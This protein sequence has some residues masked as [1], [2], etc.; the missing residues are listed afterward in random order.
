MKRKRPRIL[1]FGPPG[2]GKSSQAALLAKRFG[3]PLICS[4]ELFRKEVKEGEALGTMAEPYVEAG[5]LVPDEVTY[6]I[7][8]KQLKE[9]A[10][11]GGF[12]LDGYPRNVEQAEALDKILKINLAV[13]LRIKDDPAVKRQ[14]KR[15]E[16][17][18]RRELAVYHFMTEPL[19]SYYRQRGVLLA[20]NAEQPSAS[21]F[22][23]LVR[24]MAKLGFVA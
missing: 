7:M 24:K 10:L 18:V 14:P 8:K 19:A 6:A 20:V 17:S 3:V 22:E 4:G 2:A 23:E 5:V 12:V 16:E 1:F 11:E 21:L 15:Q 9:Q 13:Q